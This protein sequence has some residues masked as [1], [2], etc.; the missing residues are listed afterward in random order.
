MLKVFLVEDECVVREGI[1]NNVDWSA[2]GFDFCGEAADGELAYPMIMDRKPDIIITDIKMPFIDGLE[3][4]RLVR[5]ELPHARIIILSGHEEFQYAREAIKLGV[6]EYLLKPIN[7]ADLMESV[8]RVADSIMVEKNEKIYLKKYQEEMK[9]NIYHQHRLFFKKIMGNH[10]SS[11]EIFERSKELG[12]DLNGLVFK[13]MIIKSDA[14][15]PRHID[16]KESDNPELLSS[17]LAE[18]KQVIL[19][20]KGIAGN[21]LLIKAD[22]EEKLQEVEEEFLEKYIALAREAGMEL[23]GGIGLV[24]HRI[25]DIGRSYQEAEKAYASRFT[26]Y[27]YKNRIS[28]IYDASTYGQQSKEGLAVFDARELCHIDLKKTELFLKQGNLSDINHFIDDILQEIEEVRQSQLFTQYIL[29][30]F[31]LTTLK[32]VEN[33]SEDEAFLMK[34]QMDESKLNQLSGESASIES[35]IHDLLKDAILLRDSRH[36]DKYAHLIHMAKKYIEE[37]YAR[38]DLSLNDLAA[39]VGLSPNH[40]STVFSNTTGKSFIRYLTDVRVGEA[41]TLLKCTDMRCSNIAQMVGYKDP[42][43]F[44]FLFKK[45]EGLSPMQ[46]RGEGHV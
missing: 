43:Y 33:L 37:N 11:V 17:I 28:E 15:N 24:I 3:L 31:Y 14:L 13:V 26:K 32:F 45:E 23:T 27:K 30:D 35:Y 41:K 39:H 9:E 22:S 42:H 18:I 5:D 40:F 8:K 2:N 19:I 29:M 20:E 34:H 16:G 7:G 44:S 10:L 36:E 4:T 25:S 1:K 21:V 6:S 46:Y 12:L 38:D